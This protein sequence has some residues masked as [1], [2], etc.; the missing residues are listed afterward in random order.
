MDDIDKRQRRLSEHLMLLHE[1]RYS[2]LDISYQGAGTH[3]NKQ[4]R[5]TDTHHALRLLDAIAIALTTGK[6]G[7]VF[8]AAFDKRERMQLVLA[9]NGPPTPDDIAAANKLISLIGD[10]AVT[11][12][13]DI[14]PFLIDRCGEN[15]DKRVRNLHQSIQEL[16]NDFTLALEERR[17]LILRPSF[18]MQAS[19]WRNTGI[20]YLRLRPYGEILLNR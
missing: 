11:H 16:Q 18:H 9:K 14:F 2:D 4:S 5:D 19:F 12:A 8:A 15:I 6:P 13:M 20:R 17:R 3:S 1:L 10:P 7:N